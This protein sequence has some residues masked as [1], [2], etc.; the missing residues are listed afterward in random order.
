PGGPAPGPARNRLARGYF[1]ILTAR[2]I[3]SPR[4]T[5]EP[6]ACYRPPRRT[7]IQASST[8]GWGLCASPAEQRVCSAGQLR[9]DPGLAD[10]VS[11]DRPAAGPHRDG[12]WVAVRCPGGG[13]RAAGPVPARLSRLCSYVAV[14]AASAGRCG[15]SC[16]GAVHARV[17]ADGHPRRRLLRAGG[18]RG[19]R[20]R[21]A[22]RAG[23]R[24]PGR[25]G[26]QR[27]GR[28][29]GLR[30]GCVRA[31]SLAARGHARRA[32]AS[33]RYEDLRGLRSAEEVFLLVLP[34]DTLRRAGARCW[35]HGVSWPTVA[36]LV[37][38]L[39]RERR[40]PE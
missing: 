6:T 9:I 5:R 11:H 23:R 14:S 10:T 20:G 33:A 7:M 3:T 22:R 26:G 30:R 36:G 1:K 4:I 13:P 27:L 38:W 35:G 31:G 12:E 29:G 28:R 40:S 34:E 24:R 17:C 15:F 21:P 18:A 37:P 2:A 32:S 8:A 25:S 16:G 39:R 19:G